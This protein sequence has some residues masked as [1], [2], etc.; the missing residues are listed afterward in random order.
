VRVCTPEIR[1]PTALFLV[2]CVLTSTESSSITPAANEDENNQ[3]ITGLVLTFPNGEFLVRG[4][5][6]NSP[7]ERA[8]LK[9]GDVVVE[10]EG[11]ST[12]GWKWEDGLQRL[13]GS[14]P[15]V[16]TLIV[17]RNDQ[18]IGFAIDREPFGVILARSDL[19]LKEGEVVPKNEAPLVKIGKPAPSFDGVDVLSEQLVGSQNFKGSVTLL[20]FWT[21]WCHACREETFGWSPGVGDGQGGL[22]C[23]SSWGCKESDTTERLN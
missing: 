10:I 18:E 5:V 2:V 8:G 17:N 4:T 3:Y 16:V 15:G 20:L 22:A 9:S 13:K 14:K 23:C 6:P 12:A 21:S 1:G 19:T 7:A 11:E